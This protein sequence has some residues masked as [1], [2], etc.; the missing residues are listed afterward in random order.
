MKADG[1]VEH[2]DLSL[3]VVTENAII[4]IIMAV[5]KEPLERMLPLCYACN[6]YHTDVT[7]HNL[8]GMLSTVIIF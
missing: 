3:H 7:S 4:F 2:P 1:Q 8:V 5:C 6:R